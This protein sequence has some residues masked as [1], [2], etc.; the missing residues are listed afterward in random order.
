MGET[1]NRAFKRQMDRAFPKEGARKLK[2]TVQKLRARNRYLEKKIKFYEKQIVD[3]E[4]DFI[5]NGTVCPRENRGII[6][7]HKEAF[8][9]EFL[10]RFRDTLKERKS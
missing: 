8:R 4:G 5:E 9:K 2:D 3:V 6:E 1:S 7:K 10:K